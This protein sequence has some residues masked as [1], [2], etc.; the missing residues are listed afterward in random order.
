VILYL[1]PLQRIC[2][3]QAVKRGFDPDDLAYYPNHP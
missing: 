3:L 2:W 1:P